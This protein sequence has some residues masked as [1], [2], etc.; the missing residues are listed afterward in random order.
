M[1]LWFALPA[2][3]L[4]GCAGPHSTGALW[5]Q[6]NLE[7]EAALFRSTDA[8]RAAG[9]QAYELSLADEALASER[10]R[11]QAALQDCPGERRPMALSEGDKVRDA[12]RL[13][14][15]DDPARLANVAQLA[16]SD[17]F[18][19]RGRATGNAQ[20][21]DRARQTLAVPPALAGAA[22]MTA[23]VMTQRPSATV[24]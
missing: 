21:C 4:V 13:R 8:E 5:A 10:V 11:V 19:R 2:L 3:L 15:M 18:V 9:A 23:A 7:R 1:R 16:L 14:A 20:F 24:S 22:P 6:Q 17:W 12:I